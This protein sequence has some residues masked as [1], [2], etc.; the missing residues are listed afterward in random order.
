MPAHW[1]WLPPR[2]AERGRGRLWRRVVG[3]PAGAGQALLG[4]S[5]RQ[6][7]SPGKAPAPPAAAPVR[8]A[9]GREPGRGGAGLGLPGRS[10]IGDEVIVSRVPR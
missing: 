7:R 5:S 4:V 10:L 3:L 6:Q 1:A 8:D 9:G 2:A